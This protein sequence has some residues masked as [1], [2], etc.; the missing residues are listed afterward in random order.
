MFFDFARG[1]V[2]S[3]WVIN[4]Q[5]RLIVI[6][7][8]PCQK[9]LEV[10]Q[11]NVDRMREPCLL[12]QNDFRHAIDGFVQLRVGTSHLGVDCIAHH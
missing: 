7:L 2:I 11:A 8:L 3:A 4:Y 10:F 9:S 6:R 12:G 5:Q 1:Q